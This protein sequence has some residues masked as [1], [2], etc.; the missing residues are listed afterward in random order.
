MIFLAK[1][2]KIL[3]P[4]RFRPLLKAIIYFGNKVNCPCC[5]GN[6]R[7]YMPMFGRSG[8]MCPV[9][10]AMER[11]RL[12]WLYFINKTNL[13]YKSIRLLHFAPE[14]ALSR[15]I[16]ALDNVKYFCGDL[17]SPKA[18]TIMDITNI[19]HKDETF[20]CLLCCHLLEHVTDDSKAIRELFRVLRYGGWALLQHPIDQTREKT[21]ENP[22]IVTPEKRKKIFG[23]EDHVR[24][25]GNDMKLSL[26]DAGFNVKVENYIKE[27][28]GAMIFKYGLKRDE[29]IYFCVKN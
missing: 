4:K 23:Q 12:I 14:D 19:P 7:M 2:I 26:E 25:Y 16:S 8:A 1:I 27:F 13:L 28:D 5:D 15:K 17:N 18:K 10:G 29:L 21:F 9:C 3:V 24:I 20:D 22:D 11:H 6:F